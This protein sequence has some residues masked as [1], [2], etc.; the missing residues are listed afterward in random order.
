M[1]RC[2]RR[3]QCINGRLINC[4]RIRLDYAG[5]TTSYRL[6]YINAALTVA[7]SPVYKP[8]Y[9]ELINLYLTSFQNTFS[10]STTPDESQFFMFV[11]YFLLEFEDLIKDVDCR[12]SIPYYDWTPFPVAPYTA[13]VW[14]NDDGFGDTARIEDQCVITGP[15]RVGEYELTPSAGGGCLKREYQNR[16]FPSRDIIDRDLLPLPANEF[17]TFHRFLQLFIGLN[18]QCF[19]GGTIC[20]NNAANDPVFILHLARL[21]S[22]LT[23]W[24]SI[25][26]GREDVR[27]S[28]DSS[29]LLLSPGFTV[30]DFSDNRDL[31]YGSCVEYA[32]PAL[33]KNHPP[34][35][36][37]LA[38]LTADTSTSSP[39][40]C[41]PLSM[42][43]F[44][45]MTAADHDFMDVKC[46]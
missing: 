30:H 43:S 39:M 9:D 35:P 15:F 38:P 10:Q 34:P 45:P 25:G 46:A 31:P 42:M 13:A 12:L 6:A 32:P 28:T 11:R 4:C 19:I 27:Y 2:G 36:V 18:V 8:R 41:A 26:D 29:F 7:Q 14:D 23:Q 16:R 21:D 1:D 33:L 17:S 40:D 5:L 37:N 3:C 20:S 44:M 24:Q 22:L